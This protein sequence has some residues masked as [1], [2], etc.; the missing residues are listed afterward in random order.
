[1]WLTQKAEKVFMSRYWLWF[2]FSD[3]IAKWR[4]FSQP[5]AL[6]NIQN[7]SKHELFAKMK[8][9]LDRTTFNRKKIH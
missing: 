9:A 2:Y 3:R 5:I 8:N 6:R 4:E 7:Q 1:M